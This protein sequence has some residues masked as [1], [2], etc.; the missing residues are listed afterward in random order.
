MDRDGGLLTVS[1]NADEST[2]CER[3]IASGARMQRTGRKA[4]R[5]RTEVRQARF[6]RRRV[7]GEES[8][9]FS[10]SI[11]VE[12]DSEWSIVSTCTE[13]IL[14]MLHHSSTHVPVSARSGSPPQCSKFSST[15]QVYE[16]LNLY[17][18][19]F[20]AIVGTANTSR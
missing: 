7:H 6:D 20:R 4:I 1:V 3:Q 10:G 11:A 2:E 9:A 5:A 17:L 8:I 15:I 18:L 16:H 14:K 19:I 12:L 13:P